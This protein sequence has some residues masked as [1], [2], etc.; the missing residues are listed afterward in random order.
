MRKIQLVVLMVAMLFGIAEVSRAEISIDQLVEQARITEGEIAVRELPRWSGA[1]KILIWDI[2]MD[3]GGLTDAVP[4]VEF[5][6]AASVDEAMQHASDVD[7]MIGFCS[8]ALI[9]AAEKLVWVQIY[10]A[11]AEQCLSVPDIADGTVVMSNM[12]KMSSPVIAEHAI[13]MVLSL[14]RNLPQFVR[15]MGASERGDREAVTTGMMPVAGK[16]LLVAGLGGI[17]T[18]VARLGAALGMRVSGTR[19]SSRSG[20]DF[21]E[22]VGLSHEL[23]TLAAEADIIVNALPLTDG[24]RGIF[25][26]EFFAASKPGAIFVN[27]GRGQTVVTDALVAALETGAISG[28]GL[29]VSDPEPLPADHVLWQREDVIITPHVAGSGGELERHAVL[30]RENVRRYVSGEPLLNVV[31]PKK[32][33]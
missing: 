26:D 16:K 13:A 33:Y 5:I 21:I 17:G 2:G 1:H 20:P 3:I 10:W 32:G 25:D 7:A 23:N 9:D 29:D 4:D 31:D 30:L 12:Q 14:A 18:E 27:V 24:T 22:Y 6:V 19:N 28:A 11:G 15:A 8:P